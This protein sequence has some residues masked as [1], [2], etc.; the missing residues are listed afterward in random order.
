[1]KREIK[2]I[3]LNVIVNTDEGDWR[4]TLRARNVEDMRHQVNLLGELLK[5]SLDME[6]IKKVLQ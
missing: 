2:S 3:V 5:A 6:T 4:H 1:M